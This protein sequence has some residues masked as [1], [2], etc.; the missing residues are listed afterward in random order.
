MT[1]TQPRPWR[2]IGGMAQQQKDPV[3]AVS[4]AIPQKQHET[5]GHMCYALLKRFG[6]LERDRM[7]SIVFQKVFELGLP[8]LAKNPHLMHQP[9]MPDVEEMLAL[10]APDM[11][12]KGFNAGMAK[13][14]PPSGDNP[15]PPEQ[16]KMP[17]L[18][19]TKRPP[20]GSPKD[21]TPK[22]R[23]GSRGSES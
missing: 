15:E 16:A 6:A 2:S 4:F 7:N 19:P 9:T 22:G 3:T 23:T 8:I 10:L 17:P 14:A 20:P 1:W 13:E 18:G 21:R 11:S 12:T 5:L